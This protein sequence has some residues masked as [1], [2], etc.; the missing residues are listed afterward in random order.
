MTTWEPEMY[1]LG[2]IRFENT[3]QTKRWFNAN[4]YQEA[5]GLFKQ[6]ADVS[7]AIFEGLYG[8]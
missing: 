6:S 1:A 3:E 2:A 7:L 4:E 8:L 5:K